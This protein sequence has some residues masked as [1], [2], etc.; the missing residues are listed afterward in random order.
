MRKN[1]DLT[2]S[3][4]SLSQISS[5]V[6]STVPRSV[7]AAQFTRMS[8]RPKLASALSM[9]LRPSSMRSRSARTNSVGQPEPLSALAMRSPRSTLRPQ[10]ARPAAPRAANS[11]ATASPSPCVPPVI[12]ATLPANCP[13]V[14]SAAIAPS[15]LQSARMLRQSMR[16]FKFG[17]LGRAGESGRERGAHRTDRRRL[18]GQGAR[19]GVSQRAHGVRP[20]AGGAGAR[21]GGRRQSR[22]GR[23]GGAQSRF[24]PLERRLARGGRRPAGRRGRHHRAEPRAPRH[25]ARGAGCRQARVLREAAR[26]YRSGNQGD[27]RRPPRPR[28]CPRWSASTT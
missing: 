7:A 13:A 25:R 28:A 8:S 26:E 6:L 2:L 18:D 12:A 5:V 3:V 1:C 17:Q 22:L 21:D 10:I 16:Y 20:R 27:G 23:G 11:R 24:C 14:P 15:L 4:K 19:G 9:K